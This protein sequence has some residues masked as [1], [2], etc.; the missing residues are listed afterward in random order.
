MKTEMSI[1]IV[2]KGWG[3]E[4]II[5][6]NDHYCGKL[7]YIIKGCKTS[8]HYHEIKHE[9]FFV[10]SGK[11]QVYYSDDHEA[12]RKIAESDLEAD[13]MMLFMPHGHHTIPHITLR[14]GDKFEVPS[15]LIHRIV[16]IEDT[17]LFEFS[18]HHEDSDSRKL[19]KGD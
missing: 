17:K 19:I 2:P 13:K 16:A 1:E 7:L 14:P 10:E 18:T 8:L 15:R 11:V 12:V 3:Y 6:N 9:T 5:V 4:K